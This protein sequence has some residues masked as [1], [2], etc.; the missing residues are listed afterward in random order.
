MSKEMRRAE[1]SLSAKKVKKAQPATFEE[2]NFLKP[3]SPKKLTRRK[4]TGLKKL[5]ASE[6]FTSLEE[7]I[8]QLQIRNKLDLPMRSINPILGDAKSKTL[9]T[10]SKSSINLPGNFD[11][12]FDFN[13]KLSLIGRLDSKN[14]IGNHMLPKRS[15]TPEPEL[16]KKNANK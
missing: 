13:S 9:S 11:L 8:K 15:S 7:E 16:D 14:N 4:T 1:G 10:K 3:L 5:S 6:K 12:N 2:K